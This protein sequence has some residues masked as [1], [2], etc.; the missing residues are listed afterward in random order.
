MKK[1]VLT[2]CQGK[3]SSKRSLEAAKTVYKD[4][5]NPKGHMLGGKESGKFRHFTP[6]I[7]GMPGK[8]MFGN[9]K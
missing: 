2:D 1:R 7:E 8:K 6:R 4:A 9:I 3:M 5:T